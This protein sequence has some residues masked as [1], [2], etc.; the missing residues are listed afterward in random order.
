MCFALLQGRTGSP[1]LPGRQG[2]N[3]WPGPSGPKV[4]WLLYDEM[5]TKTL[6][7][8]WDCEVTHCL[9]GSS[10]EKY[11]DVCFSGGER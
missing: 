5:E 11:N 3:G 2:P 4:S 9:H 6:T 10:G 8:E 7:T 1:G